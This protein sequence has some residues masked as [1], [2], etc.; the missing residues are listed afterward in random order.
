MWI[1]Q[2]EFVEII[3]MKQRNVGGTCHHSLQYT[4]IGTCYTPNYTWNIN[5][6]LSDIISGELVEEKF[7]IDSAV[8]GFPS[9]KIMEC[10]DW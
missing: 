7:C 6:I 2:K 1:E 3:F 8:R 4:W 5:Y 10:R 9:T